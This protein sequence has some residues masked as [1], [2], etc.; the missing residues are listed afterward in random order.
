MSETML[1]SVQRDKVLRCSGFS[2]TLV[3]RMQA[4]VIR[5]ETGR[6]LGSGESGEIHVRN[7]LSFPGLPGQQEDQS[8]LLCGRLVPHG[9][10]RLP[11]QGL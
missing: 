10:I 9:R 5:L 7:Q 11:G 3:N 2:D 4:K 1:I 6:E 8:R